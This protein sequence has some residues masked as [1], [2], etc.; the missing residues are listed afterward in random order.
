[1]ANEEQWNT[2]LARLIGNL[3][4]GTYAAV[5]SA[6][7]EDND[8]P[9]VRLVLQSLKAFVDGVIDCRI[10]PGVHLGQIPSQYLPVR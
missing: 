8:R 4:H 5:V 1:M 9:G 2:S 10:A 7:G 6:V 3:F